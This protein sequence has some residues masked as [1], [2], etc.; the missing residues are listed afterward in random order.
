MKILLIED[1]ILLRDNIIYILKN[2]GYLTDVAERGDEGYTKAAS[3]SYDL[4]VL[5]L[6]LPGMD[7]FTLLESLRLNNIKTPVLI[8]SAKAML[9]DKIRAFDTGCDD[10][11]TKPFASEELLARI[12]SLIRRSYDTASSRIVIGKL[13]INTRLKEVFA[14]NTRLELTPKE[15]EILEFLAYNKGRIVSRLSIGEHIWGESLD[16]LTMSNFIDVHITNLRKKIEDAVQQKM[17]VTKR[18]NGFLLTDEEEI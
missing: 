7:G 2:G 13:V 6:M 16:L 10:Y 1:N 17:I 8:L 11:L 18:G 5:D 14:G 4:I 12:R 3:G 9:D 15:Y